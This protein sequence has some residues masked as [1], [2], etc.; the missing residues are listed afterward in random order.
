MSDSAFFDTNVLIY[1]IGDDPRATIAESLLD[2][3]GVVS[4]QV[5]NEFVSVGRRRLGMTWDEVHEAL[6]AIRVLCPEVVPVTIETH[7]AALEIASRSGYQIYDALIIAAALQAGCGVLYSE[8]LQSGQVIDSR[9][10]ILNPFARQ[11][12]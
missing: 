7:E 12:P 10:E 3:G 8:D 11:R 6:A 1:M 5:L 4:V 9:L 2:E